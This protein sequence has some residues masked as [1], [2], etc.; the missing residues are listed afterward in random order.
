MANMA[1]AE[2]EPPKGVLI[3]IENIPQKNES[4]PI[5]GFS[6]CPR[7]DGLHLWRDRFGSLHCSGCLPPPHRALIAERLIAT[8]EG[9]EPLARS[10]PPAGRPQRPVADACVLRRRD[11]REWWAR[12]EAR[13]AGASYVAKFEPVNTAKAETTAK[14]QENHNRTTKDSQRPPK[15]PK[16]SRAKPPQPTLF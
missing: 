16:D 11:A 3:K 13:G 7:C 2:S 5:D 6:A 15:P 4:T 8:I 12:L 1:E 9:P 10:V 14:P